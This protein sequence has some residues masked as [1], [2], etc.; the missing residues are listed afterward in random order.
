MSI[1]C[2]DAFIY[3]ILHN[4]EESWIKSRKKSLDNGKHLNVLTN[5]G[6]S[7]LWKRGFPLSFIALDQW[8]WL[9]GWINCM[10]SHFICADDQSECL[11]GQGYSNLSLVHFFEAGL[12]TSS[13]KVKNCQYLLQ[14][15]LHCCNMPVLRKSV[16]VSKDIVGRIHCGKVAS[17]LDH[18]RAGNNFPN[19]ESDMSRSFTTQHTLG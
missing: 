13:L 6:L 4:I 7:G 19:R 18:P 1:F 11:H 15:K 16:V 2:C 14:R 3:K 5:L 17:L 8:C 10:R 9:A 12:Y